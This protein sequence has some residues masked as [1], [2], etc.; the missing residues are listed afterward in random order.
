MEA[1]ELAMRG[2]GEGMGPV[3]KDKLKSQVGAKRGMPCL[4]ASACLVEGHMGSHF[5]CI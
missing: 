4:L 1:D 3:E 2:A 5:A